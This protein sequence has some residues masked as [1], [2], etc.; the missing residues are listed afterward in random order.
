M[1]IQ[2]QARQ[3]V[4]FA[5]Q[6]PPSKLQT[7]NLGIVP[8]VEEEPT[9]PT[10]VILSLLPEKGK[11]GSLNEFKTKEAT[12]TLPLRYILGVKYHVGLTKEIYGTRSVSY[13]QEP[14]P[15]IGFTE[16]KKN[17]QLVEGELEGTISV[18]HEQYLELKQL[19]AES[20]ANSNRAPMLGIR[21]DTQKVNVYISNEGEIRPYM[22]LHDKAMA[23]IKHVAS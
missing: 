13:S 18:N 2:Y 5:V 23:D 19:A 4:P 8:K 6:A 12:D 15:L 16:D 9:Y 10:L 17:Y 20:K 14:V 1:A 22:A 7:I 11:P 3:S 21:R